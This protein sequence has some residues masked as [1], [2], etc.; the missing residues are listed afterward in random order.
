VVRASAGSSGAAELWQ[1]LLQVQ[2]HLRSYPMM[3]EG[4]KGMVVAVGGGG[5]RGGSSSAGASG[6]GLRLARPRAPAP[7]AFFAGGWAAGRRLRTTEGRASRGSAVPSLEGPADTPTDLCRVMR[8]CCCD[9]LAAA[10]AGATA[11]PPPPLARDPRPA[12]TGSS[13]L[14]LLL[15]APDI[16]RDAQASLL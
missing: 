15:C 13:S 9:A 2:A 14:L 16:L 12:S 4:W 6:V 3:P 8:C 1:L 11:A 10:A 5:T 7:V